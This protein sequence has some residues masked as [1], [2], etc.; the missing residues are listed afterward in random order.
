ML[1]VIREKKNV[2]NYG[3]YHS[4]HSKRETRS[5]EIQFSVEK[6]CRKWATEQALPQYC[7]TPNHGE[8]RISSQA[9]WYNYQRVYL[10]GTLA[11][12]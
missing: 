2:F 8:C 5:P 1:A 12:A 7:N 6:A 9:I 10:L 3:G 11:P 4:E